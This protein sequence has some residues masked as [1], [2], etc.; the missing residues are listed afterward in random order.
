MSG[1]DTANVANFLACWLAAAPYAI[2]LTQRCMLSAPWRLSRPRSAWIQIRLQ[3]LVYQRARL[4]ISNSSRAADELQINFGVPPERSAVLHNSVDIAA[5][6]ELAAQPVSHEWCRL[7]SAQLILFVGSLR[8]TKDVP[9]ALRAF[10]RLRKVRECRLVVLGEGA[11][12]AMLEKLIHE[13]DI[14]DSAQLIV[15]GSNLF[16]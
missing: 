5:L 7:K 8:R 1:L 16:H 9:T 2:V 14:Q 10:A 4:V 15:F 13:L 11:E 6:N 12:R 3:G